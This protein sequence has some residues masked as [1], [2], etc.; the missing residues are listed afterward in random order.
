MPATLPE[1]L[2]SLLSYLS[3]VLPPPLYSFLI[4]LVSHCLA[5]ITA[6]VTL[7]SSLLSTHPSHWDAQNVL[8]PLITVVVAYLGLVA[9]YRTTSWMFRTTIWFIKWGAILGV[10]A[11]GAGWVAGH[12]GSGVGAY[13]ALSE[14]GRFL[15]GTVT[16]S[17]ENESG[18]SRSRSQRT[19]PGS[20]PK[21]PKAWESFQRHREWRY[22]VHHEGRAQDPDTRELMN[23]IFNA[24]GKVLKESGWW[25]I[26]EGTSEGSSQKPGNRKGSPGKSKAGTSRSR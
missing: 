19:N 13:S 21:K 6:L 24:A 1:F 4:D 12:S 5:F 26:R 18:S 15:V 2:G 20:S 10:L 22:Q 23:D 7:F 16:R 17:V 8:P 9:F 25:G 3:D 14:I 11:A